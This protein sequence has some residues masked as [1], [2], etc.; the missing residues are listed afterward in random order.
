MIDIFHNGWFPNEIKRFIKAGMNYSYKNR[1]RKGAI[2]PW[3]LKNI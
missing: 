2:E 1:A 3:N